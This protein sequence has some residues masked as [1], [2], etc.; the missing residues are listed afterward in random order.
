MTA[1][2]LLSVVLLSA[3]PEGAPE[4]EPLPAG[5][6]A[7]AAD[8]GP[9]AATT[10]SA[11]AKTVG[12]RVAAVSGCAAFGASAAFFGTVFTLSRIPYSGPTARNDTPVLVASAA[13]GGVLF[14]VAG[15]FLGD[16]ADSG[17]GWAKAITVIA[18]VLGGLA[19][20]VTVGAIA[21]GFFSL[22]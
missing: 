11:A 19:A 5:P 21:G 7:P 20:F 3:G 13:L 8:S 4:V 2:A 9:A 14:G 16:A 15:W 18:D 1:A 6:A 12:W 22:R 10:P 17:A